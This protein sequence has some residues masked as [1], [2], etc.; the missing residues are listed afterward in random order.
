MSR[1]VFDFPGNRRTGISLDD[2]AVRRGGTP[3]GLRCVPDDAAGAEGGVDYQLAAR[4]KD[5]PTRPSGPCS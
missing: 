4:A 5:A 3:L 2:I 1:V